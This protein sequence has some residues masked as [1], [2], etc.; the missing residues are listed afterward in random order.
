MPDRRQPHPMNSK[1]LVEPL[2]GRR[3]FAST[4]FDPATAFSSKIDFITETSTTITPGYK[5]DIGRAFGPRRNGGVYGWHASNEANAVDRDAAN[6]PDDRYD[7]FNE[8]VGPGS[9]WA[10]AVPDGRYRVKL[11]MGDPTDFNRRDKMN[12]EGIL[13]LDHVP[14]AE[15]PWGVGVVDVNVSDGALA[16]QGAPGG[17]NN[18]IAFIE[19]QQIEPL[20]VTWT[21]APEVN[22]PNARVEPGTVQVGNKLYRFGGYSRGDNTV[23]RE[24][25]VLDFETGQWS[26]LAPLPKGAAQSHA[27]VVSD[28]EYI[29]WVGGQYG[30]SLDLSQLLAATA[31]YRYH[32]ATDTWSRYVDIPEP[33]MAGGLAL[34]NG[35]LYFSGGDDISRSNATSTHWALNTR[36]KNPSWV[37]RA[38]L[39]LAGDHKGTAVVDGIIYAIGGEDGHGTTYDQHADVFAYNP[40][41]DTWTRK[42]SMPTPSS[43]FEGATIVIGKKILVLGGRTQLPNYTTS[44]ARVYDTEQ[45]QWTILNSIPFDRLGPVGGIYNGRVFITN[46]YSRQQGMATESYWGDLEG[47]DVV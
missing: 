39:P 43:H 40:W 18:R 12:V 44:Q 16:I 41:T 42:A 14:T 30:G 27:G 22:A 38:P 47:F 4:P 34:F 17:L 25:S 2:E 3:L 29:Y 15:E 31:V 11:V 45:N 9:W 32:I 19:I 24:T 7:T 1:P 26:L 46:G 35:V 5:A 37:T 8:F 13:A 36:S 23:T 20:N 10:I 33:R 21:A 6:S 28:G